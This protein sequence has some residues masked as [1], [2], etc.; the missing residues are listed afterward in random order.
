MKYIMI[1]RKSGGVTIAHAP[2]M[3]HLVEK[4]PKEKVLDILSHKD[5]S[6]EDI[7]NDREW[8]NAWD[9]IS[10]DTK[11]NINV[12]LAKEV[13]LEKLRLRRKPLLEKLDKDYLI[14]MERGED[15]KPI[16]DKK[17]ALRDVTNKLKSIDTSN[18][19]DDEKLLDKLRAERD[20][21]LEAL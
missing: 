9:D 15:T 20:I 19:Y 16:T 5:I 4:W 17:Q 2:S 10:K 13:A 3:E 11:V 6:L 14:A 7:P 18:K 21:D 8:R 1:K 12:D